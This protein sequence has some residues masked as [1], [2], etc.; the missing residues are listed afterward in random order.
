[1]HVVHRNGD[2]AGRSKTPQSEGLQPD[3]RQTLL[4]TGAV[5][6]ACGVE[7]HACVASHGV[8]VYRRKVPGAHDV[9]KEVAA[10]CVLEGI[11]DC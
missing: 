8:G 2:S 1:M 3:R 4:T 7:V 9:H 6:L 5:L 11:E 10:R